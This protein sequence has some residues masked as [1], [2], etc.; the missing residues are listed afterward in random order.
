M[1]RAGFA[2]GGGEWLRLPL[3]AGLL[4]L[5]AVSGILIATLP[6]GLLPFFAGGVLFAGTALACI[7]RPV[8]LLYFA[9]LSAA[10]SDLLSLTGNAG[11]VSLSGVRWVVIA[12]LGAGVIALRGR[13]F[14]VPRVIVPF[15]LFV[16]WAVARYALSPNG[17]MGGK[18]L[19]LY[20][21]APIMGLCGVLVLRNSDPGA[22]ERVTRVMLWSLIIPVLVLLGFWIVGLVGFT[23]LGPRGVIGSRATAAYVAV[24]SAIPLGLW[25]YGTTRRL[26]TAGFLLSAFCL[27][28]VVGTLSRAAT[29]S[30]LV[31]AVGSRVN[32]RKPLRIVL[33]GMVAAVLLVLTFAQVPWFRERNFFRASEV[34]TLAQGIE[35]F[36]TAGRDV[37]WPIVFRSAVERPVLGWGPGRARTVLAALN[38][39]EADREEQHPHNEY[40]QI[41]HDL[42]LIGLVLLLW[43]WLSLVRTA[44]KG[45][46]SADARCDPDASRWSLTALLASLAVLLMALTGNTFHYAFLT[47]PLFILVGIWIHRTGGRADREG[48]R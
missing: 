1:A 17:L 47:V 32:P 21:V 10:F 29:A 36:N 5:A 33:A 11:G 30:V 38:P 42:G 23:R 39:N 46:M 20:A 3:V 12:A 28:V 27:L 34:Q 41:F 26:R 44:W 40:L 4:G 7:V 13:T 8:L 25:R 45:W 35:R 16:A 19:V 22:A 43:A 48:G 31:L 9:I 18:D 6:D 24:L 15:F 14:T 2:G 37:M